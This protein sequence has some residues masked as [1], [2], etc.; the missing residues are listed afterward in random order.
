MPVDRNPDHWKLLFLYY[1]PDD[2]RL[3]VRKRAG[4]GHTVNCA[5]PV[6]WAVA[7]LFAIIALA[8]AIV[9][10]HLPR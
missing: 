1:N 10:N 6:V 8:L 7:S 2:P 5:R 9:S 4:L 3:F